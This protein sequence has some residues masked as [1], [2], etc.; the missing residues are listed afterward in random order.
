MSE[1]YID[2]DNYMGEDETLE[3]WFYK[4]FYLVDSS[5]DGLLRKVKHN[6]AV[7]NKLLK[8]KEIKG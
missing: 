4:E 6:D 3:K 5:I 2:I 8:L 1:Y 7:R